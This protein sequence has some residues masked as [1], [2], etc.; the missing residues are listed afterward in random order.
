MAR[1]PSAADQANVQGA[2]QD[3]SR[4]SHATAIHSNEVGF[5]SRKARGIALIGDERTTGGRAKLAEVVFHCDRRRVGL[6]LDNAHARPPC[7]NNTCRHP[8][9]GLRPP[10]GDAAF[11][12]GLGFASTPALLTHLQTL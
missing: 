11:G 2:L 10:G 9:V 6:A 7:T 3:R 5:F 8:S 4:L 1:V 12:P